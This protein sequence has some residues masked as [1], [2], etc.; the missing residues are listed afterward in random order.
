MFAQWHAEFE[1]WIESIA[2]HLADVVVNSAGS[3]HWARDAGI[4]R[5]LGRKLAD[6]LS[7]RDKDL[8]GDDKLFELI[9][10]RRKSIDNLPGPLH[11]SGRQV[12]TTTTETHVV[13]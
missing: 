4:D 7:A 2:I 10:K 1:A 8:I 6:I 13:A 11:P 3:K 5:Q 12:A 9:K